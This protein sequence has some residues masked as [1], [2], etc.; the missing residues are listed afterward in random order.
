MIRNVHER[1]L[2]V[3]AG[4]VGLVLDSLGTANDRLWPHETWPALRLDGPL[5][6]GAHGGHGPVRYTVQS[7]EPG[8]G[9]RF[10]FRRPRGFIGHHEYTV[11]PVT[12]A[13]CILRHEIV[14]TLSRSAL[15]SW[16]LF[17]RPMHDALLEDSLH[18]AELELGLVPL[19]GVRHGLWVRMLRQLLL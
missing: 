19:P 11:T 15:L 7:Y 8:V 6:A 10:Q 3:P 4:R 9:I 13:S 14:M 5:A 17:F 2:A 18:K 12:E 1:L 16:P